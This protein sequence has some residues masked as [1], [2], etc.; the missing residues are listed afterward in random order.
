[1]IIDAHAMVGFSLADNRDMSPEFVL[2]LMDKVGIDKAC[3]TNTQ[4]QFQ[5]FIEGNNATARIVKQRPDRFIGFF[6]TNPARYFGVVEE[7]D[8]CVDGLGLTALRIFNNEANFTSG[9]GAGISGLMHAKLLEKAS[10]RGIPVYLDGGFPFSLILSFAKTYS[11]IKFI[12]SGVGYGNAAEAIIAA[13]EAPN[14]WLDIMAMDIQDG[15]ELLVKECSADKLVFG[16]GIP[17][18]SPSSAMLMV[19]KANIPDADKRKIMGGNLAGILG[20]AI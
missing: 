17:L 9:W 16:T 13:N 7:I 11:N 6:A 4:C 5:D 18:A 19:E 12:A 2:S 10:Q 1:M 20:V 15:V 14:I 3:I 8:R